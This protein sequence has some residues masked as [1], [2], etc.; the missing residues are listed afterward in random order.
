M[1]RMG[2]LIAR[3]HAWVNKEDIEAEQRFLREVGDSIYAVVANTHGV[4]GWHLN[5]DLATWEEIFPNDDPVTIFL[6]K[7]KP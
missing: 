3:L 6:E 2:K 4:A 5:G 7:Y 1:S